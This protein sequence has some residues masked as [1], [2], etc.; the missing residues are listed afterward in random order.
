MY[1]MYIYIC[2]YIYAYACAIVYFMDSRV[3]LIVS[4]TMRN[5]IWAKIPALPIIS[6]NFVIRNG[7]L[8][9]VHNIFC[10]L[11]HLSITNE[12]RGL[13]E[14]KYAHVKPQLLQPHW[15]WICIWGC[16]AYGFNMFQHGWSVDFPRPD[17]SVELEC[18]CFIS[19]N[20]MV[21]HGGF[22]RKLRHLRSSWLLLVW[23][24]IISMGFSQRHPLLDRH[25]KGHGSQVVHA[26]EIAEHIMASPR[27]VREFLSRFLGLQ[28]REARCGAGHGLAVKGKNTRKMREHLRGRFF[29]RMRKMEW[30]YG[31]IW[32][33]LSLCNM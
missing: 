14:K 3:G 30:W 33:S 22:T 1:Y 21:K 12:A 9:Y 7:L 15:V 10:W 18:C 23:K 32:I 25:R 19:Q 20:F 16:W 29:G 8:E 2:I 31:K 11:Q 24:I 4:C 6:A 17:Q 27:S 28:N 5:M 26:A 13:V